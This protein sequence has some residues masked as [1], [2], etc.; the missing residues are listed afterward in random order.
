MDMIAEEKKSEDF[1]G[2]LK[3]FLPDVIGIQAMTFT[4]IDVNIIGALARENLPGAKIVIGGPHA[5]IFPEET[6]SLPYVDFVVM[7]EGEESFTSLCENIGRPD[8]LKSIKGLLYKEN[9]S[10]V[11]TGPPEVIKDLDS[12][13]FPARDLTPYKKYYSLI[14][15]TRPV[16]TVF[17]SR[18][19][20]FKCLF[21]DRPHL[22]KAFRAR[23]PENI[24]DELE[25][26]VKMGIREFLFYD[27]TFTVDIKR[28]VAVCREIKKRGLNIIWD[29]RARVDCVTEE[30]LDE[31]KSSGGERIHYG[32]EAGTD[33]ILKEL[34]KGITVEEVKRAFLM[35][36]KRGIKILAYFMIG[37][38]SE[39]EKD[40]RETIF[41][42]I[43][44]KPD[45][46]HFS[47]TTPF[48]GTE[49]YRLGMEKKIFRDFWR[50]FAL[51]P[52]PD[53]TPFFWEEHLS[54]EKL[55]ELL[56]Q[57]YKSFYLRPSY[58]IGDI[59][60]IRSCGEFKNK[61]KAGVK[62]ILRG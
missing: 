33:R 44:L 53:F 22:G 34:K 15:K 36:R 59:L 39:T 10:I 32:V 9:G 23:S 37:S 49:L 7:G 58:I 19:C 48:P 24:V 52:A 40:I 50:E 57:A 42:A 41:L 6:I 25:Q 26:C 2:I 56:K 62:L 4:M 61:L 20:P 47:I 31:F 27:D 35:T 60:K 11:K 13:P 12:L 28:A 16:T 46:V 1:P 3:E 14:A 54:R 21:C 51:A 17:T 38:P 8:K 45:Y 18:G 55:K 5:H 29:I 30:F 43:K